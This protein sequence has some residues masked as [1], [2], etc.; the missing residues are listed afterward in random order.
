MHIRTF[1]SII[2]TLIEREEYKMAITLVNIKEQEDVFDDMEK[3]EFILLKKEA[4]K[5]EKINEIIKLLKKGILY[6]NEIANEVNCLEID[7]I[8]VAREKNIP[9]KKRYREPDER[10]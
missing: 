8:R 2:K 7:V 10:F 3:E 1:R 9:I 4:K 6:P 5:K